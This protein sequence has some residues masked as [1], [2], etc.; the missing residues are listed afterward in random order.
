[1]ISKY[2]TLKTSNIMDSKEEHLKKQ[3]RVYKTL[4]GLN[5]TPDN[6]N[7]PAHREVE[8]YKMF[9]DL[10]SQQDGD[11]LPKVLWDMLTKEP[12]HSPDEN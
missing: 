3:I 5:P 12:P 9:Y 10:L 2:K 11:K 6:D 1:M 8:V 7:N 4:L